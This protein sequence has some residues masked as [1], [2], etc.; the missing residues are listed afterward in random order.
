[1]AARSLYKYFEAIS[2]HDR[3]IFIG[4]FSYNIYIY[5]SL[6]VSHQRNKSLDAF[7]S[8]ETVAKEKWKET[9]REKEKDGKE[10]EKDIY[11]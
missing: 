9:V 5:L 6:Y 2:K 11:I 10:R 8:R 1:M 3:I 4:R 7:E